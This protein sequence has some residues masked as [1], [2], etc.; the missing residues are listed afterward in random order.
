M[1]ILYYPWQY[2]T[3]VAPPYWH[4]FADTVSGNFHVAWIMCATV[5]VWLLETIW[6][7][8]P[9]S[10]IRRSWLRRLTAF[11]GIVAIAFAITF[12]LY[13]AQ[14]LFWGPAIR[15]TKRDAAP[16]WRWLHVGE[17]AVFFLVPALFLKFYCNNWPRRFSL[18]VNVLARTAITLAA[19]VALYVVYYKTSHLFLGTQK[20]FSHPQQF[21]MIPTIWLIDIWLV[22]HW[23]MDNW[24]GWKMV[25]R[26]AEEI[27][28]ERAR[29]A[30]AI[31]DVRLT[32]SFGAGLAAGAVA[33]V[34][35]FAA[36]VWLMPIVSRA[37]T[38]I[39]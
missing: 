19:G 14:E 34:A 13:F 17:T 3:A 27:A 12:F 28:E 20:G 15:G 22:H 31:A 39:K 26:T 33:G 37:Y 8:F 36:A 23:F 32:Q 24:P 4:T 11:F 38:V 6:E 9:F 5:T 1:G 30:S 7:R 18:P 25:P 10:L 2:F 16:D 21:P 29:A 35:L